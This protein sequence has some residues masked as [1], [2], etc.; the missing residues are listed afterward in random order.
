M[1]TTI[2]NLTAA[3]FI[4][5]SLQTHAQGF[6]YDQ[7]S[8]TSPATVQQIDGFNLQ[9]DSPL[10]Q[11]FIPML[12]EIGFIQLQFFDIS[13]N[14]TSGATVYVNLWTGSPNV[15]S[16]TF[17]SSTAPVYMPNG[18]GN[19]GFSAA[20]TNFYFS[21][22]MVLTTGQTYYIQPIVLSGDDPWDIVVLTNTYP[23]GQLY[24]Q[25][26]A[27]QPGSDL[28]FREG[29]LATPEPTTLALM[30]LG[31]AFAW[32]FKR[33]SKLFISF[34]I[35]TMLLVSTHAQ[36]TSDSVVQVAADYAGL[37][38]VAAADLPGTGTF[39]VLQPGANGQLVQMPYPVLPPEMSSLPIYQINGQL[40]SFGKFFLRSLND[41]SQ[42]HIHCFGNA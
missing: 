38:P 24:A 16:A 30:G 17:I 37:T 21:T 39:I 34:G 9:E 19:N 27:L 13:G 8:A 32:V 26:F 25:G 29:V 1:K 18:F 12:N 14:G 11:S 10:T 2:R 20:V 42:I 7:Q 15:N 6:V 40:R 4:A 35:G 36:T 22:P 33:R 41:C 23:N 28:W 3:M 5:A 31:G